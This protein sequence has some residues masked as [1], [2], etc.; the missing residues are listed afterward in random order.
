MSKIDVAALLQPVSAEAPCGDNLE[1]D[2]EFRTLEIAA[3]GKPET[4][5][6]PAEP[7][8]WKQIA[9]KAPELLKRSRDLRVLTHL[10][11]AGL[12]LGDWSTFSDCLNL[13]HGLLEQHWDHVHPQLDPDDGD[14]T[15]R[16]NAVVALS[17]PT[18]TQGMQG[19]LLSVRSAPLV[20]S[21]LIGQF[22][23]RDI[24]I[25]TGKLTVEL[26][27]DEMPKL[28]AINAAFMDVDLD[29]LQV[30]AATIAAAAAATTG[31]EVVLTE[32]LGASQA[33][34]LSALATELHSAHKVLVEQLAARGVKTTTEEAAPEETGMTT[35]SAATGG[36]PAPVP[37]RGEI[38]SR[39]DV[40][41]MLDKICAYYAR[42]EP[43]SPVP[44]LLKR[45]KRLVSMDFMDIL[46]DMAPDALG[47]V[48]ALRGQTEESGG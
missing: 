39:E 27:E 17:P 36:G 13:M 15:F 2:P 29:A 37:V 25:A 38:T 43:S 18:G 34:D 7:P 12:H 42:H 26:P 11:D 10:A 20:S 19:M 41:L 21:R 46:R 16:V 28:A 30:E 4:Q 35:E 45:A 5:F 33:P 32:R 8:D 3:Q 22:D 40:T 24:E 44:L 6:S 14:P 1:Y 23:L 47:P 48:Q 9:A 31:I